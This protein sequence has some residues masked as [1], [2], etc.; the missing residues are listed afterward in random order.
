MANVT[1][2]EVRDRGQWDIDEVPDTLL[3]SSA[4]IPAGDAWLNKKLSAAGLTFAGLTGDD[5]VLAK[6]AEIA[7][8]ASVVATRAPKGEFKTGLIAIK[9]LTAKD[10]KDMAAELQREARNYL[11]Q[12]G[13]L[14]EGGFHFDSA[15]GYSPDGDDRTQIDFT[16]AGIDSPFSIWP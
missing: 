16:E 6:A 1:A 3:N 2:A 9:D 8:V 10:L 13:L 7:A 14:S 11:A 15:G 5:Q 12:L 4:F